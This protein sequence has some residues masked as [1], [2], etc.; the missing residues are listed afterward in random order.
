VTLHIKALAAATL[1]AAAPLRAET[2]RFHLPL[3]CTLGQD[4]FIQQYVDHDPGPGAH[5]FTCAPHSYDGHKGTDFALPTLADLD[6]NVAVRAAAPGTV[7]STRNDMPDTLYHED[8]A[9]ALRGRDCGNG[10]II[11]HAGGWSTQYCHMAQGSVRVTPGQTVQTGAPLGVVGLSGRTQFPHLHLTIREDDRIVDPFAP[12]GHVA[13]D[14][15]P[16]ATLWAKDVAYM[17]GGLLAI[18]FAT[19]L[20]EFDAVRAGKA[21]HQ[22]T[23]QSAALV[24]WALAFGGYEDDS[25]RLDIT[26]PDG[27]IVQHDAKLEKTQAQLFRGAGKRRPD[28]GWPAGDYTGTVLMIRDG[29]VI[30]SRKRRFTLP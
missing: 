23:D 19:G 1:F 9:D 2:P 30:D 16:A 7:R 3:A 21:D 10:L 15:R 29:L 13:C 28:D 17:P 11:D 14:T 5:D 25:L 4:C 12:D 8:H 22:I 24:L 27:R 6:R 18:G 20:P 26:G